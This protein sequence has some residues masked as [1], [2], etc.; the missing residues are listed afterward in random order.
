MS[1][2]TGELAAA[3]VF[4]AVP[5][6]TGYQDQVAL[7]SALIPLLVILVQ[8]G[9]YWL[10]AR[11]WVGQGK[12]PAALAAAYRAFRVT[13]PAL[14]LA[15]L[16]GVLMWLPDRPASVAAVGVIW[17]FGVVE[18]LNYFVVRLAYPVGRWLRSVGQWRT[19][20]LIQDMRDAYASTRPQPPRH[21]HT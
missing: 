2:G 16:V 21:Q 10:L 13:D 17:L 18:Y 6:L 15:G 20:R 3:A 7:W 1:L 4:A 14:L 9:T 5:Q 12:M 19:P 11:S 8:A